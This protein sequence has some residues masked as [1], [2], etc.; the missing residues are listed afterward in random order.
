LLQRLRRIGNILL[1]IQRWRK[2]LKQLLDHL[3]GC[4]MK[5][6]LPEFTAEEKNL[7][8]RKASGEGSLNDNRVMY[9]RRCLKIVEDH[10]SDGFINY[11]DKVVRWLHGIKSELREELK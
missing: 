2:D 6:E 8:R 1:T 11:T 10:E 5:E 7:L 9:Y 4:S 3:V